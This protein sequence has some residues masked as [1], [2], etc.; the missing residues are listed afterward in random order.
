MN[1]IFL[2]SLNKDDYETTSEYISSEEKP[3]NI[4]IIKTVQP[5]T[6]IIKPKIIINKRTLLL[7]K[8]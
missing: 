7:L 8:R 6:E 5:K 2:S 4:V 1:N 3:K